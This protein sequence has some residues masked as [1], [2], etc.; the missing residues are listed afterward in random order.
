MH[1]TGSVRLT[2][3]APELEDEPTAPA[4]RTPGAVPRAGVRLYFH[5]PAYQVVGSAWR[6]DG[7]SDGGW[8]PGF[9]AD[10]ARAGSRPV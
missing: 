2:P 5:G 10:T 8:P 7:G 3:I 4:P 9:A 6:H 1:F